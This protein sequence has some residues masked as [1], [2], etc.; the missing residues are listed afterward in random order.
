MPAPTTTHDSTPTGSTTATTSPHASSATTGGAISGDA[1][2]KAF[3]AAY[4]TRQTP[5][6][7]AWQVAAAP[8]A[9]PALIAY[10]GDNDAPLA[11]LSSFT[12]WRPTRYDP[13]QLADH[14]VATPARVQSD[15]IVTVTDGHGQTATVPIGVHCYL[16]ADNTW[17]VAQLTIGYSGGADRG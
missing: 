1:L 6:G 2:A 10:L 15:W 3:L 13:A 4:L 9:T 14:E 5:T 7:T 16:T 11:A 17:T 8:Y 12:S